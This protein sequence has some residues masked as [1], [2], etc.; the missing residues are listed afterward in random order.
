M[1]AGTDRVIRHVD[2]LFDMIETLVRQGRFLM[3]LLD[4]KIDA[5]K[6]SADEALA[7]SQSV[8]ATLRAQVADLQAQVDA[9]GA[10]PERI[11]KLEALKA[12]LDAIDPTN[13]ATVSA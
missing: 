8:T 5:A 2:G 7:R 10:T 1:S 12:T 13:P 4:D 3:A 11:A 6:A 9:G